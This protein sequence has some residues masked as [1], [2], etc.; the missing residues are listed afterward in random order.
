MISIA[1]VSFMEKKYPKLSDLL[2]SHVKAEVFNEYKDRPDELLEA[3]NLVCDLKQLGCRGL[4]KKLNDLDG[5]GKFGSTVSEMKVA[6]ILLNNE[7]DVEFL[8]E[9]DPRFEKGKGKTYKSP[10]I[11]CIDDYLMTCIEVTR[12]NNKTEFAD[13]IPATSLISLDWTDVLT[14]ALV[15]IIEKEKMNGTFS[16]WV[17]VPVNGLMER[18]EEE[19]IIDKNKVKDFPSNLIKK[20]FVIAIDMHEW[21][22]KGADIRKKL[23]GNKCRFSSNTTGIPDGNYRKLKEEDWKRVITEVHS[24]DSWE[25]IEKA[26]INGW[27]SVLSEHF[28]IPN[29]LNNSYISEEG[30]FVSGKINDVSAILIIDHNNNCFFY[31]NP[32]CNDEIN[33]PEIKNF[34]STTESA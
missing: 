9:K 1:D 32:F 8:S 20:P 29:S 12:L 21:G 22:I 4:E 33:D 30:I 14:T 13:I 23:Y 3:E 7:H 10:D 26:K 34:I 24:R 5:A 15:K 28:L 11:I 17:N 18:V 27:G 31:P 25:K 2:K 6:K 19:K 16:N